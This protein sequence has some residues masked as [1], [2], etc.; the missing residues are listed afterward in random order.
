MT[1]YDHRACLN[2]INNLWFCSIVTHSSEEMSTMKVLLLKDPK[3]R[4]SGPDPYIQEFAS[5]GL[6]AT[7]IPTL[8]FEFISLTDLSQKLFHPEAYAGLI[9]TSPRAV[10]AVKLCLDEKDFRAAWN[11]S[12]KGQWSIKSIYVV[13]KSTSSLVNEIGLATQ[14]EDSGNAEKLAE[15]IC[16]KTSSDSLPLLFPC[17]SLKR[18][19]LPKCLKEKGVPLEGITVY[20]T[21]EHPLI[22]QA[23]SNYFSKQGIPESITFFSP[24][25]IKFCL[26]VIKQLSGELLDQI[27]FAAIGPTTA[28]AMVASGLTVAFK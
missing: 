5:L 7:L 10:D 21:T 2:S 16:N 26:N 18:E 25:G 17:G 1:T 3:D 20:R 6:Q 23:L 27:K 4:E 28:D 15:Y 11:N 12:L 9:F 19:T 14:G 22:Q 8:S 13:G 24:S